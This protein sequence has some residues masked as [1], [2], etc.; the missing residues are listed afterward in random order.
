MKTLMVI[1]CAA[2]AVA[3]LADFTLSLL[4]AHRLGFI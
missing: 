2:V 3:S 4:I 1:F